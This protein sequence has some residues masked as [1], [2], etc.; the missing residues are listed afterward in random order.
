[1]GCNAPPPAPC[2]ARASKIIPKLVAEPQANEETVKMMMQVIRKRL[3]PNLRENQLLAG[4]TTAFAT[5]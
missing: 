2:T 5:R 1:M 4:K 3:R